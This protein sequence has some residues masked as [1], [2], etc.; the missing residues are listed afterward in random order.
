MQLREPASRSVSE[1]PLRRPSILWRAGAVLFVLAIPLLLIAASVRVVAG[2]MALYEYQFAKYNTSARTNL[3]PAELTKTARAF[4]DYFDSDDE[5]LAVT[6]TDRTGRTFALFNE[7]E[8]LHMRDV[9]G[10]FRLVWWIMI[11]SGLWIVA[12]L[13]A[14][15]LRFGPPAVP[16]LRRLLV[17]GGVATLALVAFLG[18]L[19]TLDFETVFLQFHLLSFS[20]DLWLLDPRRD[21]LIVLFPGEF[22]F[23][24]TLAIA[25]L[26][27]AGALALIGLAGFLAPWLERRYQERGSGDAGVAPTQQAVR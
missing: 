4:I 5:W 22:F 23:E 16:D 19:A 10:L 15:I 7:R 8:L 18:G 12:Y 25:G 11:G 27:I 2:E 26:T 6:V 13:T 1:T 3:P 14:R 21:Y 20:N 17:W 9:K 24:A